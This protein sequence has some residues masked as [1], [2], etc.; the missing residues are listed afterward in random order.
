MNDGL[1]DADIYTPRPPSA[2]AS[3][4]VETAQR[5]ARLNGLSPGL[6]QVDGRAALATSTA[7][8]TADD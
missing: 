6:V 3:H 7:P 5:G 4:E 2:Q 1:G 8:W